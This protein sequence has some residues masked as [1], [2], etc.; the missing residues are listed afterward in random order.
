[1]KAGPKRRA[2]KPSRKPVDEDEAARHIETACPAALAE[3]AHE[4]ILGRTGQALAGQPVHQIQAGRYFH[5][6]HY[7]AGSCRAKAR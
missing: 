3:A 4:I 6:N 5:G 7:A 2:L 1:M